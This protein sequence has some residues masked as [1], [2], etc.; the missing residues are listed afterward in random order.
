MTL[1]KADLLRRCNFLLTALRVRNKGFFT[2]YDY[3][4]LVDWNVPSYP[5][6][7]ELFQ[8]RQ[9]AF[10]VF[11]DLMND[12]E[13]QFLESNNGSLRPQ[14]NSDFI[15]PLDGAAIY[16]GITAFQ[17]RKIIEIGSGNS[18]YFMLR[19]IMDHCLP[20][21]VVCIDPLPRISIDELPLRLERR[22]LGISDVEMAADLQP[23][24]I[25]FIDSS[26]IMQQGFDLDIIMNRFLPRLRA[27]VVVHFHDIFLP[28]AYPAAW[29]AHRFNEQNALA[30]WL[31]SGYLELEFSS[32]FAARDMSIKLEN[33]CRKI[34]MVTRGNG[35]TL[36]VRKRGSVASYHS[37]TQS[38]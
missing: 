13:A 38:D 7:H 10:A 8:S 12:N 25:L 31:L 17:P 9:N 6:I 24:D 28:Y 3:V 34:P 4:S 33:I 20:T 16:T 29:A 11:L 1:S 32:Q 19:A 36:W 26:H 15:C 30:G 21:Q 23:N 2:P 37:R 18:T 22:T 5:E 35:G 14:W 27:G